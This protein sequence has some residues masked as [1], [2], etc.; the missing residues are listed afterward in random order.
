MET[1]TRRECVICGGRLVETKIARIRDFPVYMG[2]KDA[3]SSDLF[4]DLVYTVCSMCG[5]IQLGE[6]IPL[7]ILYKDN[8]NLE[9]VGSIWEN[10]NKSFVEF[11][12]PYPSTVF[13]IGDPAFKMVKASEGILNYDK[14]IIVEPNPP[15]VYPKKVEYIKGIFDSAFN[16]SDINANAVILSHSL[17]HMYDPRSILEKIYEVLDNSGHLYVSIPNFDAITESN[18]MPPLGMHF[19]HTYYAS[20]EYMELLF[21]LCG[22]K[23]TYT[24]EYLNHSIFFECMKKDFKDL[25]ELLTQ[26]LTKFNEISHEPLKSANVFLYG[27]HFPAQLF[28]SMG[29]DEKSVIGVL[30]NAKSKQGKYL[31]GTSLKVFPPEEIAKYDDVQVICQMGPYT[32]EIKERLVEINNKVVL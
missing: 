11:M 8:H 22:F 4:A 10:H 29:I 16:V 7:D 15:D 25:P 2:V 18:Y 32:E 13:E 27:A 19:E 12:L 17:E 21:S 1:I 24:T 14:W 26:N 20:S 3:G 23:I 5:C 28:L 9:V 30:D 31:Y 6:L